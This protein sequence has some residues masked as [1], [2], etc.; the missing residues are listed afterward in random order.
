MRLTLGADLGAQRLS[1]E[2][3]KDAALLHHHAPLT[4]NRR[5]DAGHLER[6]NLLS[7]RLDE[8]RNP[9][10]VLKPS[11]HHR[12]HRIALLGRRVGSERGGGVGR[13]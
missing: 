12:H 6:Q 5:H 3:S 11:P 4:A 2:F 1:V 9:Q 10:P 13:W 7:A 8:T